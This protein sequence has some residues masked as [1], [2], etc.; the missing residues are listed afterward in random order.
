MKAR[1][2][3]FGGVADTTLATFISEAAPMVDDEW[4]EVDQKPAILAL[5]AHYL[6]TEGY[7]ARAADPSATV[8]ASAGK[9]VLARK[10]GDV[11]VQYAQGTTASASGGLVSALQATTYGRRFAQ[12][13][14]RNAPRVG[15][16]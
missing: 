15:L 9:E 10:V 14:K 3:E 16:V 2:P 13:M 11:S 12:L 1:Y 5:A 6:S 8:P 4:E 7:P